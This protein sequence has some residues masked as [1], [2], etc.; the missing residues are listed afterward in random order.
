MPETQDAPGGHWRLQA[1]QLSGSARVDTQLEPQHVPTP[2]A[3]MWQ[4]N[5]AVAALQVAVA[6]APC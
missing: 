1:P 4:G 6:Q 3:L 2:P 5:P